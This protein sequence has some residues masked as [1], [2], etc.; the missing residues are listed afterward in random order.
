ME[1]ANY[2]GPGSGWRGVHPGLSDSSGDDVEEGEV[3]GEAPPAAAA[4]A[5]TLA[6]ATPDLGSAAAKCL[7]CDYTA[8]R[9][10]WMLCKWPQPCKAAS[11]ACNRMTW[12]FMTV[13][14]GGCLP[15]RVNILHQTEGH[16]EGEKFR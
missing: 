2:R 9:T 15:K 1:P 8:P 10:F 5:T 4:K 11:V 14:L 16:F 3:R 12:H 6:G 7:L 13:K